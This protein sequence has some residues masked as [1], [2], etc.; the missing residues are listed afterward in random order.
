MR[1]IPNGVKALLAAQGLK[2]SPAAAQ[3][4]PFQ[5]S[6]TPLRPLIKV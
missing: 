3:K 2:I 4:T 1:P 6:Y 5:L